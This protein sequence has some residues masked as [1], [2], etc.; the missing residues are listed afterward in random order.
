MKGEQFIDEDSGYSNKKN[1]YEEIVLRQIRETSVLLSKE[2]T[3]SKL[4]RDNKVFTREDDL[5]IKAYNS[6]DTLRM[7]L[8]P[9]IKD[10]ET[11]N[12]IK[13]VKEEIDKYLKERGEKLITVKGKEYKLKNV[14]LEPENIQFNLLWEFKLDKARELFEILIVGYQKNK[15]YLASFETE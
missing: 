1:S 12:K 7:L 4:K 6:I 3:G 11:K 9:F 14:I 2:L 13:K 10:K 8:V 5:R 15:A